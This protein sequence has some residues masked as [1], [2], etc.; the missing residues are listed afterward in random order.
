MQHL[1]HPHLKVGRDLA[2]DQEGMDLGQRRLAHQKLIDLQ[3]V[4]RAVVVVDHAKGG[5]PNDKLFRQGDP[6]GG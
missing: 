6:I 5:V 3:I 1:P 2:I 4:P